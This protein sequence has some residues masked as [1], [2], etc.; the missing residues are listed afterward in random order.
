MEKVRNLKT[1]TIKKRGC[2]FCADMV[3]AR[4]EQGK[5]HKACTHDKRPYKVLDKYETYD[6]FLKSEDSRIL[7]AQFFETAANCY[8][9]GRISKKPQK[10]FS[11]GDKRTT[12]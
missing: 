2:D 9:L 7:V 6:E 4:D 1:H 3:K 11:D 10:M 12:L 5:L 8:T